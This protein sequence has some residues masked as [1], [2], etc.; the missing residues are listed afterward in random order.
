VRSYYIVKKDVFLARFFDLV[1]ARVNESA[2]EKKGVPMCGFPW[3]TGVHG[4]DLFYDRFRNP[5][6]AKYTDDPVHVQ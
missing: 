1:H 5:G 3:L 6:P 2:E 4:F